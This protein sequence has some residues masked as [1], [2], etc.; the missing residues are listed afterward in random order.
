MKILIQIVCLWLN[1]RTNI[2]KKLLFQRAVRKISNFSYVF[3]EG[4]FHSNSENGGCRFLR[5]LGIFVSIQHL[6]TRHKTAFIRQQKSSP[7]YEGNFHQMK[8]NIT[9]S[10]QHTCTVKSVMFEGMNEEC[11]LYKLQILQHLTEQSYLVATE[12]CELPE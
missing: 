3:M 7:K 8:I 11:F 12:I 6:I 2:R 5:N 10:V 4:K 9:K 1:L